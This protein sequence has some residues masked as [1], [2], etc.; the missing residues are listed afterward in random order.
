MSA[1]TIRFHVPDN[2]RDDAQ[3]Q[4]EFDGLVVRACNGDGHALAAI[5][6]AFSMRLLDEAR[7]ELGHFTEDA[8]AV[9]RD[10][11]LAVVAGNACFDPERE[12]AGRW[13]KRLVREIARR[14]RAELERDGGIAPPHR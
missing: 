13:M 5:A 3:I 1:R 11:F 14:H 6:M 12:R 10:F 4:D 2:R 7:M 8:D 9:L